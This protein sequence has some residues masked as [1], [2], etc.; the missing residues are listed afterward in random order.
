MT[1]AGQESLS[2]WGRHWLGP[3]RTQIQTDRLGAVATFSW[4]A[5]GQGP[6]GF[7]QCD[8][9]DLGPLHGGRLIGLVEPGV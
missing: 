7:K 5:P 8:H 2:P 4:K 1:G 9:P 3:M 6:G